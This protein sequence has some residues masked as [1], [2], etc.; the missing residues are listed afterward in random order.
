M[1]AERE[2]RA[3]DPDL[4][5]RARRRH[6]HRRGREAAGD[7]GVGGERASSRSTRP[8]APPRPSSPSPTPRPRASARWPRPSRCP[9]ASRPCSCAS[10]SST[11][12]R[13]GELAK[14]SNTHDP[15]GQPRRRRLDDRAG[16]ERGAPAAAPGLTP[17]V[18]SRQPVASPSCRN[19]RCRVARAPAPINVPVTHF[20]PFHRHH[21]VRLP[22]GGLAAE[23]ADRRASFG[24]SHAHPRRMPRANS[25]PARR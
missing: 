21:L 19:R 16:D 20:E 8:R 10:P 23:R 12:N 6:Q 9:A 24:Q 1:R 11:S 4:R 13:F 17:S 7:Q 18:A 22:G 15:A 14:E 2:K 5:G 3:V 25:A